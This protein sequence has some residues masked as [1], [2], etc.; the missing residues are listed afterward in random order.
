MV[1][2]AVI[3]DL[4]AL[5]IFKA[6]P[7]KI[8]SGRCSSSNYSSMEKIMVELRIYSFGHKYIYAQLQSFSM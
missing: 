4:V 3:T 8:N 7:D 2:L 5:L 1:N 6:Y